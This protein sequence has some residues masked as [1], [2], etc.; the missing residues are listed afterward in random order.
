MIRNVLSYLNASSTISFIAFSTGSVT[1]LSLSIML[2]C[3]LFKWVVY[4][5]SGLLGNWAFLS[6]SKAEFI[7]G[8]LVSGNAWLVKG[9]KLFE[10]SVNFSLLCLVSKRELFGSSPHSDYD[11]LISTSLLSVTLLAS[12]CGSFRFLTKIL[13]FS[14]S[15][16]EWL[17]FM[18]C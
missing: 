5:N 10:I 3:V 4:D 8:C 13:L 17:P 16:K 18:N 14:A 7:V 6:M 11:R 2:L 12:Y 15:V 1:P 9:S